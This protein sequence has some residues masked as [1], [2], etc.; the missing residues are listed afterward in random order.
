MIKKTLVL[1]IV[2][3]ITV[4]ASHLLT[5]YSLCVDAE[6]YHDGDGVV[7]KTVS[8]YWLYESEIETD[9]IGQSTGAIM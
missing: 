7:V 4:I 2:I 9:Y 1:A 8:G 6:T 3:A 5:M